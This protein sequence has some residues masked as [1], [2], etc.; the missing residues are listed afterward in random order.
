[1][2][3]TIHLLIHMLWFGCVNIYSCYFLTSFLCRSTV[4]EH[5]ITNVVHK[6][7]MIKT[8]QHSS[9]RRNLGPLARCTFECNL[10]CLYQFHKVHKER[11]HHNFF[12]NKPKC[13]LY[14]PAWASEGELCIFT[15]AHLRMW[16]LQLQNCPW[17]LE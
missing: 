14:F 1:M 11:V 3:I 6:L 16:E 12:D 9:T 13:T 10:I 8:I 15:W 7:H 17:F 5:V 2:F 4:S